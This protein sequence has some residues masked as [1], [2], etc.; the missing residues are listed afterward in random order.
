MERVRLQRKAKPFVYR[1]KKQKFRLVTR[2][3]LVR[4]CL[5]EIE[6]GDSI[7]KLYAFLLTKT[8]LDNEPI[9]KR[10]F[11]PRL[12]SCGGWVGSV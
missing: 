10:D 9:L 4:G 8:L 11:G 2:R 1:V 5:E 12:A 3:T 6:Q 7:S